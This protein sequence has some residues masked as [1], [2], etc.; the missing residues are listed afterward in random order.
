MREERQ[1]DKTSKKRALDKRWGEERWGE[2]K[3]L[4]ERRGEERSKEN[5]KNKQAVGGLGNKCNKRRKENWG[6]W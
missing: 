4:D 2:V 6:D 3:R 5:G 1:E